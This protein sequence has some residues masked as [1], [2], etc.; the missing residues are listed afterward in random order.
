MGYGIMT[1]ESWWAPSAF[2]LFVELGEA[3][4]CSWTVHKEKC[5]TV[6][7]TKNKLIRAGLWDRY[8]KSSHPGAG[9]AVPPYACFYWT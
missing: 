2:L 8:Y 7:R 3:I 6:V 1:Q 5:C 9:S 4:W